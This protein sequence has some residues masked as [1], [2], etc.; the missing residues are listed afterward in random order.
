MVFRG[1]SDLRFASTASR[2]ALTWANFAAIVDATQGIEGGQ[3]RLLP[4]IVDPELDR[5]RLP[6]FVR[7]LQ[8][9]DIT[10]P[11]LGKRN[12]ENMAKRLRAPVNNK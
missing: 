1:G 3:H 6:A 8:P 9:L 4:L 11:Y 5:S 7:I 12:W 2:S 10:H